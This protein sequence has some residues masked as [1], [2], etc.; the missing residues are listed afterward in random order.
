M[1]LDDFAKGA[2]ASLLTDQ[3]NAKT[4]FA[5]KVSAAVLL[6]ALVG[7]FAADGFF[8]WLAVFVVVVALAALLFIF[9]TKRLATGIINRVAPP[10]DLGN[11]GAAFSNALAEAELPT[12]PVGFLNLIWRLRKGV[13]PEIE[14]LGAVVAKLKSQLD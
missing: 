10:A 1:D 6:L 5:T 7:A 3:V 11:A 12:G 9:V 2:V 14:R 13:G 4:G 8:R